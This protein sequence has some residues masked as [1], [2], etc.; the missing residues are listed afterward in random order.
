MTEVG[1]IM[2]KKTLYEIA[3]HIYRLHLYMYVYSNAKRYV[4]LIIIALVNIK[5]D[6]KLYLH[7]F[8][9]FRQFPAQLLNY[10]ECSARI[11]AQ[12]KPYSM[13]LC[14][15]HTMARPVW[16]HFQL[17]VCVSTSVCALKL[18]IE[19]RKSLGIKL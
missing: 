2:R 14:T 6:M 9:V 19:W 4:Y 5:K 17:R 10:H 15:Y 12:F 16:A 8:L 13:D 7:L 3:E 18:S 11:N 1:S